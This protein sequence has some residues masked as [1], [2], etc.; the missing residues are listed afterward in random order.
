MFHSPPSAGA[1]GQPII[2]E[3]AISQL[4]L[5]MVYAFPGLGLRRNRFPPR[6]C[7]QGSPRPPTNSMVVMLVCFLMR[8][9]MMG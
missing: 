8:L 1:G 2:P 3:G 5:E 6:Q 9:L 4:A 7:W